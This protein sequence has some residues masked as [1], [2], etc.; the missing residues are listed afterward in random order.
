MNSDSKIYLAGHQGMVGDSLLKALK[1]HGYSNICYKPYPDLDLKNQTD[2]FDYI[3]TEK[4]EYIFLIAGQVGGILANI[5]YPAKFLY[6]NLIISANIIEA[7]RIN[8]VKKLIFLGS[9]CIYPRL[10]EQPMKEEYLLTGSLEPTNEGYA[11]GKIAG[12]KLCEYYCKQYGCNF[13]AAMPPNLFGPGDNYNN[14]NSHVISALIKKLHKGK[15]ENSASIPMWGT[16][17][18]RREFMLVSDLVN[19]LI[20]LM[21]NYEG[22]Q[23]IN[24]GS[25]TD[26]S[27]KELALLLKDIIG[28]TGKFS[29]DS[30][31]PDG[32][33]RKLMDSTR[34]RELG[35]QPESTLRTGLEIT[36]KRF[37][38]YA[39]NV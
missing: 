29:W 37:L 6:D 38:E 13:I 16:G 7:A 8:Q 39:S 27:I 22:G 34:I 35:W 10:S 15:I 9:S 21:N 4:P 26:V 24:I 11:I 5:N 19:G 23:H 28:Y 12:L 30:S 20:Y 33:P 25:G 1:T 31:K 3:A 14:E 32:M 36:Y 18:A 17:S 2:T